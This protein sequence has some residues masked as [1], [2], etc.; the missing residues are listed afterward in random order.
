M[1]RKYFMQT[2]EGKELKHWL[3]AQSYPYDYAAFWQ[4]VEND[5]GWYLTAKRMGVKV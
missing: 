2:K 1:T 5:E 3:K 4:W